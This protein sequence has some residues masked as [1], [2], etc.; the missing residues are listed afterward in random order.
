MYLD[1]AIINATMVND[2]FPDWKCRFYVDEYVNPDYINKLKEL[3]SEIVIKKRK[4][5]ARKK[6]SGFIIV[7]TSVLK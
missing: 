2:I 7:F 1:G 3:G 4:R 5:K 6:C